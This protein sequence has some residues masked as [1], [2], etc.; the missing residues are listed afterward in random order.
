MLRYF[1]LL[2]LLVYIEW[3]FCYD[4]SDHRPARQRAKDMRVKR[5]RHSGRKPYEMEDKDSLA[6]I[7]VASFLQQPDYKSSMSKHYKPRCTER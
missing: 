2:C 6:L 3:T 5:Q 4:I 1:Y 7:D